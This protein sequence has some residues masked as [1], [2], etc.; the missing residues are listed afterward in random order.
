MTKVSVIIPAY[1]CEHYIKDTVE[2]VLSQTYEDIELIII[3]DGSTDRTREIV[4]RFGSK[5]E[6]V[7]QDKN[8]G[9]SATR[10]RGIE[11]AKGKY[12]AFLDH[13]DVWMPNKI[14]EQI[15]LLENNKDIALVYSNGCS[16]NSSGVQVSSTL[17]DI[18]KPH[19]GFA[20]EELI[21]DNFIPTSSVIV[22][23]Q[24]LNEVGGFNERFLISQDFDLYLRIAEDHE[25]DFVDALLFK[26]RIYPDSASNKKRK[27]LLDDVISITKF[28]R[29]KIGFNNPRL[30]QK[31]DRKIAKYM[32]HVAIWSLDHTNR[33]EAL[34]RYFDCIRTRAFDYKIIL[35]SIFFIMPR[36]ISTPLVRNLVK[37][38]GLNSSGDNVSAEREP[39]LSSRKYTDK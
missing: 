33:Q 31:L 9:P 28:Y 27:V 16:I 38:Q 32:F 6:Y 34:G 18:A 8:V 7:Y 19:R 12:I 22:R 25:I 3:D 13:D 39:I 17:F 26:R 11:Q 29:K 20:F 21:L 10:N 2:S 30:V 35:G 24:I 1:N 5:V 4:K 23:K 15:K 36:F 37:V 14:E